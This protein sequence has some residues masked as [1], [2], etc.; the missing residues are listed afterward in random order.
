M[1]RCDDIMAITTQ[2]K[3]YLGFIIA[4]AVAS[5]GG[6]V[7]LAM[8]FF[9]LW[10]GGLIQSIG[11]EMPVPV[12]GFL[13][14][15]GTGMSIGGGAALVVGLALLGTG[16]SKRNAYKAAT[17]PQAGTTTSW[18]PAISAGREYTYTPTPAYGTISTPIAS[19]PPKPT[20][21]PSCGEALPAGIDVKFCPGCGAPTI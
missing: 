3:G 20:H 5:A 12:S 10:I 4:G 13:G 2:K 6:G 15:I 8:G 1:K 19:P 7:F 14:A 11:M 18:Q 21:C 16:V 17:S 9:Y